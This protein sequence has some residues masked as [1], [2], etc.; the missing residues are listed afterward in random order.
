MVHIKYKILS[1]LKLIIE[2]YTGC[3]SMDDV[4]AIKK[5]TGLDR[6]Y[7][8][9][10]NVIMDFRDANLVFEPFEVSKYIDFAN[11]SN[12]IYGE[13]RTAFLTSKPN[14]VALTTIF[15]LTKGKLPIESNTFSTL[16]ALISWF[17]LMPEDHKIVL[18]ELEILKQKM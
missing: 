15:G 12:I 5:E 9:N 7:S 13:R 10:F 3:V 18:E 2:N 1:D 16:D 17:N 11:N 6:I 14:Q 8:P 4:I